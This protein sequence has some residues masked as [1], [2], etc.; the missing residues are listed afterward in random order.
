MW[1]QPPSYLNGVKYHKTCFNC[2]ASLIVF[3]SC[4][5]DEDVMYGDLSASEPEEES[6]DGLPKIGRQKKESDSDFE[7]GEE[8][9]SD[10]EDNSKVVC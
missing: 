2:C 6:D 7:V 8:S 3:L 1:I 5:T 9:G 4:D 10:W